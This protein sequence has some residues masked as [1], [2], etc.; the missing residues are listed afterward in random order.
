MAVP[1]GSAAPS[2]CSSTVCS[3]WCWSGGV[4]RCKFGESDFSTVNYQRGVWADQLTDDS[5]F[6]GAAGSFKSES[7]VWDDATLSGTE[8]SGCSEVATETVCAFHVLSA[9]WS[10]D[11]AVQA[12]RTHRVGH[13]QHLGI[14][15]STIVR[16][17]LVRISGLK[18]VARL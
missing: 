3:G 14:L 12:L 6:S 8:S 9:Y 17:G 2:S 5:P 1:G 18:N 4:R 7:G 10:S 16:R 13:F 15:A 11:S